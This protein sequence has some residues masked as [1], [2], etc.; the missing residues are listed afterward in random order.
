MRKNIK[1]FTLIEVLIAMIVLAIMLLFLYF[2]FKSTLKNRSF[3]INSGKPYTESYVI[4]NKIHQ[5]IIEFNYLY[6]IFIGSYKKININIFSSLY[7]SGLSKKPVPFFNK[8][9]KEN[10]N[11][12]Y[13]KKQKNKKTYKL[14]YEQSFFKN[15]NGFLKASKERIVIARN[16]TFFRIQY[17]YNGIWLNKFNY[18]QYNAAPLA[19]KIK[20]GIFKNNIVK[21][22][23]FQFNM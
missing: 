7:F 22:F 1:G 13:T 18:I 17:Y 21:R 12:F 8:S 10:I 9:S 19:V 6:P 14:I 23:K 11:Y 5:K 16:L 3:A 4:Y 20:F 2:I 15:K